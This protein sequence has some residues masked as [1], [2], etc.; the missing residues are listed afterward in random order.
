[1]IGIQ[2]ITQ[3]CQ[4]ALKDETLQ[5][6]YTMTFI[7]NNAGGNDWEWRVI[8][9]ATTNASTDENQAEGNADEPAQ[10]EN[11][12]TKFYRAV[13]MPN[14]PLQQQET[15]MPLGYTPFDAIEI[16]FEA[17]WEKAKEALQNNTASTV[18]TYCK[19]ARLYFAL[20]PDAE[21]PIWIFNFHEEER[22]ILIGANS[23]EIEVR[24]LDE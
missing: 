19:V 5:S 24:N 15:E 16:D 4:T 11:V 2:T 1:M 22:E 13:Q 10:E 9:D 6:F 21:E 23:G 12:T 20:N 8:F 14:Q 3:Q 18:S 17:A 7:N